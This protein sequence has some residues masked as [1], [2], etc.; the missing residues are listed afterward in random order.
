MSTFIRGANLSKKWLKISIF[1]VLALVCATAIT[2]GLVLS[3]KQNISVLPE[4]N[5]NIEVIDGSLITANGWNDAVVN[6]LSRSISNYGDNVA[7]GNGGGDIVSSIIELGGIKWTVVYK[8][9]GVITLFANSPVAKM[10]F[11]ANEYSNSLVRDY[12]INEFYPEF[13]EKIGYSGLADYIVSYGANELYYQA[14][15]AQ[16]VQINAI[17]SGNIY[18]NDGIEGDLVW[19]PSAYELGGFANTETSPKS[20]VNSFKTI[21]SN[22]VSVN[23]GLWNTSN[24]MRLSA[25]GAWLRS[26]IE[27]SNSV[28]KN[29]VVKM[30]SSSAEYDVRPC[31][32]LALPTSIVISNDSA[33]SVSANVASNDILTASVTP[34]YTNELKKYST[35][36]G[37]TFTITAGKGA[38]FLV[39]LSDAVMAGQTFSG[40][41]I[42]MVEDIDMSSVTIW[43]PIGRAGDFAFAGT[44]DGNGYKISNLATAGS[45]LVG[46]FGALNGATVTK[47]GVVESSWFSQADNCGSIAGVATSSNISLCYSECGV[48]GG[49]S[50]GGLVGYLRSGTVTNSYN[51]SGISAKNVAGGVVGT[52]AGTISY[53]YN[54]GSI[55]TTDTSG[56]RGGVVASSTGTVTNCY[57]YNDAS[58]STFGTNVATLALMQTQ[59]TFSGFT[60]GGSPWFMSNVLNERMPMLK[61][62]MKKVTVKVFTDTPSCTVS[63]AV[64]N[65]NVNSTTNIIANAQFTTNAHYRFLGWYHVDLDSAGNLIEGSERQYTGY[66]VPIS[67]NAVSSGA[68]KFTKSLTCDDYYYLLAKF[69][70]LYSFASAPVSNGF[71]A[72]NTGGSGYSITYSVNGYDANLNAAAQGA[73]VWYPVGTT[74]V[75]KMQPDAQRLYSALKYRTTSTG[76]FTNTIA[77]LG[78]NSSSSDTNVK[79]VNG[80]GDATQG[81]TYNITLNN[82]TGIY[83]SSDVYNVQPVFDRIYVASVVIGGTT[84]A[85]ASPT[86]QLAYTYNGTSV[87][88]SSPSTTQRI[89]YNTTGI[90]ATVGGTYNNILSFTKWTATAGTVNYSGTS[91]ATSQTLSMATVLSSTPADN[92]TGITFTANFAIVQKTITL[93][94]FLNTTSTTGTSY[95][96]AIASKTALSS[97][98]ADSLSVTVN[99]GDTVY[100]Y[101]VPSYSTGYSLKSNTAGAKENTT[102]GVWSATITANFTDKNTKTYDVIYEKRSVYSIT[103][104]KTG[105]TESAFTLPANATGLTLDAS[106]ATGYNVTSTTAM[107][108]KYFLSS[109]TAAVG[110]KSI[111]L[112]NYNSGSASTGGSTSQNIFAGTF[113]GSNA[114]TIQGIFTAAG[115]EVN[116]ANKAITITVNFVPNT[117][118]L[119]VN[120]IV[121]GSKVSNLNAVTITAASG[122]VINGQYVL[123]DTITVRATKPGY[124]VTSMAVA[125]VSE[126]SKTITPTDAWGNTGTLTFKMTAAATVTINY[127]QR[128]YTV[129]VMD[130][131]NTTVGNIASLGVGAGYANTYNLGSST[132]VTSGASVTVKYGNSATVALTDPSKASITITAKDQRAVISEIVLFSKSGETYTQIGS[133][134]APATSYT[135]NFTDNYDNLVVVF[136]YKLLQKMNVTFTNST[137]TDINANALLVVLTNENDATDRLVLIVPL[138]G[139]NVSTECQVASYKVYTTVAIFVKTEMSVDGSTVTNSTVT[140]SDGDVADVNIDIK[141]LLTGADSVFGSGTI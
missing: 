103:F 98:T 29:G 33:V 132:G 38:D 47:V 6:K 116:Y 3:N 140:V 127:V 48:S 40:Y 77:G 125:G 82:S 89:L 63:G 96:I 7:L 17:N 31:I 44:F 94:E 45:G 76:S 34:D 11:G 139:G 26:S 69:E 20:R 80:S 67:G 111:T 79:F 10:A 78:I 114:K 56:T 64:N 49:S 75:M 91:N 60:F 92:I 104:A 51:R 85:S 88:A 100:I 61:V 23:T 46:L 87:T 57:K 83:N 53:C 134:L 1:F 30:A 90:T 115:A 13:I 110:G 84:H 109:V 124:K 107:A 14:P 105:D 37:T 27:N 55:S 130:N 74:V 39:A 36:S 50:V 21:N 65:V 68:V 72:A 133:A 137:H 4:N 62:F 73:G 5:D 117:F 66:T 138:D 19:L 126:G 71:N 93:R 25:D 35:L 28:M 106:V 59:S 123:N 122:T 18:N 101:I 9:N 70:R 16:S 99:Y 108:Q 52:S 24:T 54:T 41:T 22:G 113:A 136:K 58:S 15:N 131:L 128:P 102:T 135:R 129:T 43:N 97:Y 118:T 120:D 12:L 95:G 141:G 8:Q 121:D 119:T 42:K 86:A 81:Y 32:N 2:L 112:I